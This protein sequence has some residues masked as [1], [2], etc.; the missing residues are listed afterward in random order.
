MCLSSSEMVF[1]LAM[2]HMSQ[3]NSLNE[4]KV[5]NFNT[6]VGGHCCNS[7]LRLGFLISIFLIHL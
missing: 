4:I 2:Q 5:I 3:Q 1:A 6:T 7:R